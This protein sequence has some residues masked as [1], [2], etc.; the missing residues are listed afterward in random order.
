MIERFLARVGTLG[1]IL[2]LALAVLVVGFGGGVV[3]HFRLAAAQNEQ[4]GDQ[5]GTQGESQQGEQGKSGSQ[6]E[7]QGGTQGESQAGEQGKTGSQQEDQAGTQGE[8]QEG[9]SASASK[10]K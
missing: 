10:T 4:Q 7:S 1:A 3:E 8:S 9:E 2:I 6:Q 5:N